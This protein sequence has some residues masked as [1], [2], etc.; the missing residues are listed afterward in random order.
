MKGIDYVGRQGVEKDSQVAGSPG[1][2]PR[3]GFT[4]ST[5]DVLSHTVQ[6]WEPPLV[7]GSHLL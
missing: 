3:P 4:A 1:E 7:F 2:S 6:G 5:R